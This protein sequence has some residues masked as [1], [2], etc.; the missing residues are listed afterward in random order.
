MGDEAALL[1]E[2]V[3]RKRDECLRD[4]VEESGEFC[5][6]IFDGLLCWG[7]AIA[8]SVARQDCPDDDFIYSAV[9][10]LVQI[11]YYE[12]LEFLQIFVCKIYKKKYF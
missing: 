2:Y 7:R 1:Q 3:K 11:H 6:L 10:V 12:S 8:G 4:V 5:G 9:K